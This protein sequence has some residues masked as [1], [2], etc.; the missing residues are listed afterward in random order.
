MV[1]MTTTATTAAMTRF[2]RAIL[3]ARLPGGDHFRLA[4]ARDASRRELGPVGL[5]H[6]LQPRERVLDRVGERMERQAHRARAAVRLRADAS[7]LVLGVGRHLVDGGG[8]VHAGRGDVLVDRDRR[9]ED[10]LLHAR[11]E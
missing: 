5:G 3:A 2:T 11:R 7:V 10:V 8:L 1:T 4:V 9:E 6:G